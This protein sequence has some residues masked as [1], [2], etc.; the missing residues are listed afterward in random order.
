MCLCKQSSLFSNI[1]QTLNLF[2]IVIDNQLKEFWFKQDCAKCHIGKETMTLFQ[3]QFVE[4]NIF[5]ELSCKILRFDAV[6][7]LPVRLPEV[8]NL[9]LQKLTNGKQIWCKCKDKLDWHYCQQK[10]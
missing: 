5:Y 9:L 10:W 3:V 1:E 7:L 4:K 2:L 6:W 8:E